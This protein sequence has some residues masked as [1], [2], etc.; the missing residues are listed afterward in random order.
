MK[1]IISYKSNVSGSLCYMLKEWNFLVDF[2]HLVMWLPDRGKDVNHTIGLGYV[3][4]VH[5]T[6]DQPSF[7]NCQKHLSFIYWQEFHNIIIYN[8]KTTLW[9]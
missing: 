9:K 2:A 3:E 8:I 7:L 4:V 5:Q 6:V 1:E